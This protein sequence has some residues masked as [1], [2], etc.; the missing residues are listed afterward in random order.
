MKKEYP[1]WLRDNKGATRLVQDEA[2][3][4]A[5]RTEGWGTREELAANAKPAQPVTR[6]K[7][8]GN[9]N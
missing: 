6:S 4:R 1:R 5:A 2:E 3:H 9:R 8:H 7:K